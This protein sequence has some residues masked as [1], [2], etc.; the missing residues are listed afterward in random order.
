[1]KVGPTIL[2]NS[3]RHGREHTWNAS[4]NDTETRRFQKDRCLS[5]DST[6]QT[7]AGQACGLRGCSNTAVYQAAL[8]MKRNYRVPKGL[9]R[10]TRLQNIGVQC[11]Q[12]T[13]FHAPLFPERCLRKNVFCSAIG[14]GIGRN[15][16]VNP[17]TQH[18]FRCLWDNVSKYRWPFCLLHLYPFA[19]EQKFVKACLWMCAVELHSVNGIPTPQN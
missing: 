1:M 16:T 3:H 5:T 4:L 14:R 7:M 6:Q 15:R 12:T 18:I 17:Q 13:H 2:W 10:S 9:V 8:E 11:T 19:N